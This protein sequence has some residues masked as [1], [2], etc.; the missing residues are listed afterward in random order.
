MQDTDVS[1]KLLDT[2]IREESVYQFQSFSKNSAWALGCILVKCSKTKERPIAVEIMLNG[3]LVFAHYPDSTSPY[4]KMLLTKK[5]AAVQFLE[6]SSLRFFA[7]NEVSGA[8]PVK[9]MKLDDLK[10]QFRGG[11]FPIR[12]KDGC[13]IGSIAVTGM[14]HTEDHA[15]IVEALAKFLAREE[16]N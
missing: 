6:K 13:V 11:G 9:D 3:L 7:E 1:K 10:M 5:H 16:S 15:L 2:C 12:L 8:D 4:Y 14:S